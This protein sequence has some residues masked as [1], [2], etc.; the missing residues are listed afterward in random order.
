MLELFKKQ[1]KIKI[2]AQIKQE[3]QDILYY[4][5]QGVFREFT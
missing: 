4:I 2:Q 3:K 5:K 1:E